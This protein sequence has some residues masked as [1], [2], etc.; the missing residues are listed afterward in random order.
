MNTITTESVYR[1]MFGGLDG[2]R[3]GVHSST[4]SIKTTLSWDSVNCPDCLK[5]KK[6]CEPWNVF[7]DTKGE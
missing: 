5:T 6:D 7:I 1:H 3:C 4:W 2:V